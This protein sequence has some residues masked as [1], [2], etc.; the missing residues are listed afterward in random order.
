MSGKS[1]NDP[2][3]CLHPAGR[4]PADQTVVL[5]HDGRA[6][7]AARRSP[8]DTR[9]ASGPRREEID[10]SRTASTPTRCTCSPARALCCMKS[11]SDPPFHPQSSPSPRPEFGSSTR[12]REFGRRAPGEGHCSARAARSGEMR[13]CGGIPDKDLWIMFVSP[14]ELACVAG[15]CLVVMRPVGGLSCRRLAAARVKRIQAHH[16]ML[17]RGVI[18]RRRAAR[19]SSGSDHGCSMRSRESA[20]VES[21]WVGPPAGDGRGRPHPLV[22]AVPLPR[23]RAP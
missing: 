5:G 4:V 13:G 8:I 1:S 6:S 12:G 23:F 3:H 22:G 15:K 11:S 2:V 17:T 20:A 10:R 21:K 7:I 18:F 14:R 19:R 9:T 16:A